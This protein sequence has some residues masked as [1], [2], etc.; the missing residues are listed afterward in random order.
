MFGNML[1]VRYASMYPGVDLVYYGNQRELEYDFVLQPG[2]NP[3]AIRLRIEGA[4]KFG[5]S[6]G[7]GVDENAAGDVRLRSPHVYQEANGIPQDVRA[8]YVITKKNE[9]G[10]EVARHD[11]RRALVI[12]PVLAYSTYLGGSSGDGVNAIAVDSAGSAYVAGKRRINRFPRS[13]QS[14]PRFTVSQTPS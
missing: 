10:F 8:R 7:S 13:T 6:K 9:V 2:S 3:S 12:D 1:R 5:S 11:P 4:S 14:G